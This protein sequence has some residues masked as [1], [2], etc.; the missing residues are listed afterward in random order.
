MPGARDT[1]AEWTG[2]Y[3]ASKTGGQ[4]RA[5][6]RSH[7]PLVLSP[8]E[9]SRDPWHGASQTRRHHLHEDHQELV[10]KY[11]FWGPGQTCLMVLQITLVQGQV[12]EALP[13]QTRIGRLLLTS[14]LSQKEVF[15]LTG[16]EDKS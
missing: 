6:T 5:E 12:W 4:V 3:S 15:K 16:Q 7:S 9:G 14:G 11:R 10:L 8:G 2:H 13:H 1:W